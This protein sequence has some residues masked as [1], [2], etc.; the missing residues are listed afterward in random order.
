M[1]FIHDFIQMSIMVAAHTY[2]NHP[3]FSKQLLIH[4]CIHT[5][6]ILTFICLNCR[7]S[8]N[9]KCRDTLLKELECSSDSPSLIF[10]LEQKIQTRME[11]CD[12]QLP[13]RCQRA[14]VSCVHR[15][16]D[17]SYDRQEACDKKR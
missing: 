2:S 3:P 16:T 7:S 9:Q 4:T 17:V 11:F 6:L 5:H 1:I 15:Y 14:I 12:R 13:V 10:W 8:E